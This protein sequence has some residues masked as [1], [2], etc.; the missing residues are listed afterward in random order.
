[1]RPLVATAAIA[2]PDDETNARA[3]NRGTDAASHGA[4][5]SIA[6]HPHI[7]TAPTTYQRRLVREESTIGAQTNSNV[8]A[9]VDAAMIAA[10][11]RTPIPA[12]TKLLPN[13][14]PTTPTGHAVQTWRKKNVIGGHV[15]PRGLGIT[16][17]T[18]VWL[19]RSKPISP[20]TEWRLQRLYYRIL[21][22]ASEHPQR[23]LR[24][25][26]ASA[27]LA[28]ISQVGNKLADALT[29][30]RLLGGQF[31]RLEVPVV[32]RSATVRPVRR[33]ATNRCG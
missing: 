15:R 23:N 7:R 10:E 26:D 28:D 3:V 13:A 5:S 20:S 6:R 9:S 29:E 2:A 14:S 22:R 16:L 33:Y 18:R 31:A 27:M 24:L 4:M 32:S 25:F 19:V 11:C 17:T 12:F 8:N 1:M 30:C 21:L